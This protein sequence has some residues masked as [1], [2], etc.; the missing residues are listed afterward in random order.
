MV[1]LIDG[2][3]LVKYPVENLSGMRVVSVALSDD[4]RGIT[5]VYVLENQVASGLDIVAKLSAGFEVL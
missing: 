4:V 3:A 5:S 2:G 1:G